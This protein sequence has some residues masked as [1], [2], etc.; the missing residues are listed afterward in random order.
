MQLT[1]KMRGNSQ[2]ITL[3]ELNDFE[4]L[5]GYPLPQDY[6]QHMLA[7]NGGIVVQDVRHINY[8][9]GGEG[10]AYLDSIKYGSYTMEDVFLAL[11]GKIPN[12]Y[13]SIGVTNNEGNIIMSLNSDSTY[14]NI[15]EWFPDG[16]INALSP[17]FT[18]LLNDMVESDE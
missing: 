16:E 5:V 4:T 1:F 3:A 7:H 11:K 13:L 8:P 17:S 15:R 12:G 2:A 10:I 14:G 9:D 6:R 18:Q